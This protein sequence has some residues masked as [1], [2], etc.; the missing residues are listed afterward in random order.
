M[1]GVDRGG[2]GSRFRRRL[3]AWLVATAVLAAWFL[4]SAYFLYGYVPREELREALRGLA[5]LA[6]R[7]RGLWGRALAIFE[8]NLRVLL[9]AAVPV[10]GPLVEAY[11]LAATAL[12]GRYAAELI[13][14][15][16]GGGWERYFYRL[17]VATP[18]FPL[19]MLAYGI[20][21]AEA[22]LLLRH[23]CLRCY[24]AGVGAA[25]VVLAVAALVEAATMRAVLG[26]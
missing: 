5:G 15:L 23:R 3:A 19:E 1:R 6:S 2:G 11:V 25:V 20:A 26:R 9:L 12:V 8:N 7:E 21:T 4:F 22:L 18:F 17:I 13:A 10:I 14:A 16:L 24:L